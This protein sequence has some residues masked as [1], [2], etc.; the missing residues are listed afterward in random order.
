MNLATRRNGLPRLRLRLVFHRRAGIV[1]NI[2]AGPGLDQ[3]WKGREYSPTLMTGS[4]R[5]GDEFWA[6]VRVELYSVVTNE[7]FLPSGIQTAH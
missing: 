6:R 2:K 1:T 4:S 5:G 7:S 3:G